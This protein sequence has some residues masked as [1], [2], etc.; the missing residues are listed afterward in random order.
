MCSTNLNSTYP[1][2]DTNLEM[3][4][5]LQFINIWMVSQMKSIKIVSRYGLNVRVKSVSRPEVSIFKG[6]DE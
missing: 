6:R 4:L 2:N 1:E 5:G 3:P